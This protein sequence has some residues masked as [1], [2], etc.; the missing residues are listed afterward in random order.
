[1]SK[2]PHTESV[3]CVGAEGGPGHSFHSGVLCPSQHTACPPGPLEHEEQT[4][5]SRGTQ[6]LCYVSHAHTWGQTL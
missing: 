3:F 5:S 6:D 1:M 4:Q 2:L